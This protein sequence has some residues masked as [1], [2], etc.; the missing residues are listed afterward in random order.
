M[1][2]DP[3]HRNEILAISGNLGAKAKLTLVKTQCVPLLHT[4]GK[5]RVSGLG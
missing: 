3:S 1:F 2:L 4:K 5:Y